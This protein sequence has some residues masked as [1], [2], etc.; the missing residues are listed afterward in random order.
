MAFSKSG[1][2]SPWLHQNYALE[3]VV[4]QY[5]ALTRA[6]EGASPSERTK[7]RLRPIGVGL[8]HLLER[9]ALIKN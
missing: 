1:F 9:L 5:P 3:V 7:N 8:R 4:A 2:E 6:F